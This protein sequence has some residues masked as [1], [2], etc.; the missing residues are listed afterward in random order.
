MMPPAEVA[1][2]TIV[3]RV[4]AAQLK[5][6]YQE[7][8]RLTT[9]KYGI[10]MKLAGNDRFIAYLGLNDL[11][12]AREMYSEPGLRTDRNT[13]LLSLAERNQGNV[14]EAEVLLTSVIVTLFRQADGPD[15][16]MSLDAFYRLGES[17]E[18]VA[19]LRDLYI[20]NWIKTMLYIELARVSPTSRQQALDAAER[21]NHLP[22]PPHQILA[23]EIK[24][25]RESPP[26]Q[27]SP[28]IS[29]TDNVD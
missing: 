28:L 14:R 21:L 27:R 26:A 9:H 3:T 2:K 13:L 22:L 17:V 25:I 8:L 20:P 4:M 19:F 18:G 11:D 10:D 5:H 7:I 1:Q 12:K 29:P 6:D 24:R 23:A 15:H 16:T